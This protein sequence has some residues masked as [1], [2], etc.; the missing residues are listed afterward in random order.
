MKHM[1]GLD[2]WVIY[3]K[4]I[5][6]PEKFV[7]RKFINDNPTKTMYIDDTLEGIRKKIPAGLVNIGRY[8]DD[9]PKIVEVWI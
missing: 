6:I 9:D 5:D 8:P 2:I 3:D 4:P 7:A 1:G